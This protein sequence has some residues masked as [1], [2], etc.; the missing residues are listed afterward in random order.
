MTYDVIV[1][2]GGPAG[3]GAAVAAAR[4]GARTLLIEGTNCLGGMGSNGLVPIIRTAGDDGGIAK[5]FYDRLVAVNGACYTEGHPDPKAKMQFIYD[6]VFLN[7]CVA[8]VIA[9]EMVLESGARVL[10]HTRVEGVEMDGNR[11]TGVYLANKGGRQLARCRLAIDATG[12]GDLAAWA[13]VPYDKGRQGDGWLQAVSLIF[14][15]AGVDVER[16]P[17]KAEFDEMVRRAFASGDLEL[18]PYVDKLT[19]GQAWPLM[20]SGILRFMFDT[21]VHIDASDPEG[22]TQGEIICHQRMFKVWR[23]LRENVPGYEES[24]IINMAS[25]LGVRETRRIRGE[26][27]LT[28]ADVLEGRKHPDGICRAS[29]YMDTHDG[30]IKTPEYK[31]SLAPPQGDYYEIPYG[32]LVP[33][34]VDGLLVSGRCIS[35]TRPANGAMR[36]QPT[37]TN[38][39]QAAGTA[40]ALCLARGL[41]P[42]QLRGQDLRT[43]LV[44]QG[45]AL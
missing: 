23:F 44:K 16:R 41:Q 6:H 1:A 4:N 3:I 5:E 29:F 21:A 7:P 27:T 18:A 20:P 14:Y 15:L 36:L 13:G 8:R 10:L 35:S 25:Y 38:T 34:D 42:R 24:V 40:A 33:Q 30:Q 32:C 37:C 43:V 39:G 11:V 22:L 26:A 45:M 12:D 2:G 19:Y 9:M 28:E 17:P 31:L